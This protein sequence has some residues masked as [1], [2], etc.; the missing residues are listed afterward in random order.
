MCTAFFCN[1]F[2]DDIFLL[3]NGTGSRN[4]PW[5][6]QPATRI[7]E[8]ARKKDTENWGNCEKE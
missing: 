8:K 1:T 5:T 3:W 4:I 7:H 6:A 2:I